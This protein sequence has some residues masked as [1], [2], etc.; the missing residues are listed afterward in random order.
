MSLHWVDPDSRC[1]CHRSR[2]CAPR[3]SNLTASSNSPFS[4]SQ[5]ASQS[6]AVLFAT[7][8]P[9][10]CRVKIKKTSPPCL[11]KKTIMPGK[12]WKQKA[13]LCLVLASLLNCICLSGCAKRD[14]VVEDEGCKHFKEL[15]DIKKID[16]RAFWDFHFDLSEINFLSRI[17]SHSKDFSAIHVFLTERLLCWVKGLFPLSPACLDSITQHFFKF[18]RLFI[19]LLSLAC[20]D[21]WPPVQLPNNNN[22]AREETAKMPSSVR[23][24]AFTENH[25]SLRIAFPRRDKGTFF[26]QIVPDP[27]KSRRWDHLYGFNLNVWDH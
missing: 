12:N 2:H 9:L 20:L 5:P 22:E 10:P 14:T 1:Y 21:C 27:P 26:L 24:L 23:L 3:Q 17:V 6:A 13:P 19:A 8:Q 15:I 4:G 11:V 25:L 16:K 18:Q 7:C